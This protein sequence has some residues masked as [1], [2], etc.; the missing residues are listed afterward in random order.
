MSLVHLHIFLRGGLPTGQK[1]LE[2][3]V[4]NE[5]MKI[6]TDAHPE[7]TSIFCLNAKNSH[8]HKYCP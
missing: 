4:F 7:V 5:G 2:K 6:S 8:K 1:T 3:R